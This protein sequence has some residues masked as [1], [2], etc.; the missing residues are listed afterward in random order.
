[1]ALSESV[2]LLQEGNDRSGRGVLGTWV[3][4]ETARMRPKAVAE[5]QALEAQIQAMYGTTQGGE[6]R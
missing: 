2:V 3:A 4:N 6:L 1:M 5:A